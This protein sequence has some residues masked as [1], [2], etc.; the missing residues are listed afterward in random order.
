VGFTAMGP[1]ARGGVAEREAAVATTSAEA[2]EHA[3][4]RILTG[5]TVVVVAEDE[6][7][8]LAVGSHNPVG[9]ATEI[10]GVATLPEQ[11]RRGLGA[12]VTD[13]LVADAVRRGVQLILLSAQ[14]DAVARV[15]ERVGFAR[16]GTAAAAAPVEPASADV[17]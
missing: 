7:G 12:A 9:D 16:V 5:R 4:G 15:Y 10:V 1:D 2:V 14:D 13:T 11:R 17:G 3:R 8:V 6:R